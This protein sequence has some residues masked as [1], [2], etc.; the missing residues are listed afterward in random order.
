MSGMASL[1]WVGAGWGGG[2]GG[3]RS[4]FLI[5]QEVSPGSAT[6]WL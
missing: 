2:D 1:T 5:I 6:S 3:G 4:V